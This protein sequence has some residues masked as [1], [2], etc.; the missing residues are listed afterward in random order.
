MNM[1]AS[2]AALGLIMLCSAAPALAETTTFSQPTFQGNRLDWCVNWA[3]GCGQPAAD[4][5]CKV[6][7]YQSATSF[8]IAQDIGAVT[9]TRL[10]GSGA[11]CDQG[12]CDG[13]QYI[14]C[15]KP[16]PTQVFTNPTY[17][18]NRLDWCVNWAQGCG[19]PAADAFCKANGYNHA[20][21]FKIAQDIGAVT[22]TRLIGS[23]AVCD[24]PFCD[25]FLGIRCSN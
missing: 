10:I 8:A 5:F 6:N 1:L 13:F 7:G 11:V 4:A 9:P 19:Q 12:M 23:G 15:F 14:A 17:Q 18:G 24:Q 21:S 16:S 2:A 25:G 22:P 20:V 3:Q